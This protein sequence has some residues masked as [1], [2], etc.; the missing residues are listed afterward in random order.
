MKI[1]LKTIANH[2]AG[3]KRYQKFFKILH[4]ISLIGMG[5]GGGS[6]VDSSGE[7]YIISTLKGS[8]EEKVIFDVGANIGNY[9]KVC[10]EVF[11]TQKNYKIYAFEPS[12]KHMMYC[13]QT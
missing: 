12:K 4:K 11:S 10:M 5:Y 9:S 6:H 7:H 1:I 13:V 2:V 3:K 8:L